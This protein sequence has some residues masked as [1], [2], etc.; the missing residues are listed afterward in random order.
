MNPVLRNFA[1]LVVAVVL[2]LFLANWLH[3][4]WCEA[5]INNRIFTVYG[6]LI[7]AVDLLSWLFYVVFF[8][9]ITG[10]SGLTNNAAWAV[11][12]DCFLSS[13]GLANVIVFGTM[14]PEYLLAKAAVHVK[15]WIQRVWRRLLTCCCGSARNAAKNDAMNVL[16]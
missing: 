13:L 1:C 7:S 4:A 9:A 2:N 15:L 14:P 3:I 5:L 12:N 6:A 11:V 10:D 16:F 8:F